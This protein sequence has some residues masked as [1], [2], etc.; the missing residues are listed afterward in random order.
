MAAISPPFQIP[1]DGNHICPTC[2]SV[3]NSEQEMDF[4]LVGC[5]GPKHFTLPTYQKQNYD[6]TKHE[7]KSL[8]SLKL[9]KVYNSEHAANFG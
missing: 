8:D 5:T 6:A 4:H 2:G 7:P 1:H 9:N 3:F